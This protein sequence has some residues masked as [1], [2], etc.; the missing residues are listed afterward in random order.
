MA[1]W[2]SIV[3]VL[4]VAY[5]CVQLRRA[6][7]IGAINAGVADFHRSRY[8]GCFWLQ[9]GLSFLVIVLFGGAML[10]AAAHQLGL[11]H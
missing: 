2:V 1:W 10:I 6:A 7:T 5:A 9:V 11:M 8:P 3:G 4:M